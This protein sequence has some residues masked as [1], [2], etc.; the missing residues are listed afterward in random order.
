M[1]VRALT[2]FSQ[3]LSAQGYD[4]DE[5]NKEI[6][7]GCSYL[8]FITMEVI[9]DLFSGAKGTMNWLA[10][11][12]RMI[13]QQGHPVAWITPLGL[14][15]VQPYRQ[16]K[17]AT[18][19]TLLQTISLSHSSPDLPL[20]KKRQ[21][22][23]FPPNYIHSL[24]SCHMLLTA[25]E[26]DRRG[27][28]FSAVHDSFWT[29]A[30]DVDE[31]NTTLRNE[32]VALYSQPLLERLKETWELRYPDITFPELPQRGDLDIESVRNAKFFFQ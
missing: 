17:V 23:A 26:M 18:L 27:L 3:Q 28:T 7:H 10:T 31:M 21:T 5:Y 22:T 1:H 9:G 32:F 15:A 24:D 13:S 16:E 8:A 29:H 30:C 4:I 2:Y 14:P 19:V 12:A 25:L 20:H 11:C 6:F